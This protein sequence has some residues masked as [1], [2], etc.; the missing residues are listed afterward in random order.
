MG[1]LADWRRLLDGLAA[2]G[3]ARFVEVDLGGGARAGLL[4]GFCL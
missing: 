2:M 3:L 1:R 4:H